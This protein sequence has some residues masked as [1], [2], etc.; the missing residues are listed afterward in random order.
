MQQSLHLALLSIVY[1]VVLVV[2]GINGLNIPECTGQNGIINN[3]RPN[4]SYPYINCSAQDSLFCFQTD[5]CSA[6]FIC[7]NI[8]TLDNSTASPNQTTPTVITSPTPLASTSTISTTSTTSTSSI[9]R[10][11]RPGVTKR[12]SYPQNCNYF[13]YC[14][15]GFLLVEQ[16]PIG[17]VFDSES[18]ACGGRKRDSADCTMK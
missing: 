6:N 2:W 12:F 11:C 17:Y 14:V 3:T 18:G 4:C 1:G 5:T 16:C 7:G 10:E 13:Y 9:R 8:D 15:D